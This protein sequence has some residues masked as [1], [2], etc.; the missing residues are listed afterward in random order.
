MAYTQ[1]TGDRRWKG[2][3]MGLSVVGVVV[4]VGLVGFLLGRGGGS[5][6]APANPPVAAAYSPPAV[7][8]GPAKIVGGVPSGYSHDQL[9]A[10][11][12]GVGFLQTVAALDAHHTTVAAVTSGLVSSNPSP[13]VGKVLDGGDGRNTGA[14]PE[15][16]DS[17]WV[18]TPLAF[19]VAAWS[20]SSA[21]VSYWSCLTGGYST[22]VNQPVLAVTLCSTEDVALSWERGDWRVA[23]YAYH[24]A[25]TTKQTVTSL[26]KDGGY[27]L[28][29]GTYMLTVPQG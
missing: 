14:L 26:V 11:S 13:A 20:G 8:A 23:D 6:S 10:I 24:P 19:K 5:A 4:V 29:G 21:A 2:L 15:G 16:I 9:G 27:R 28:L 12:A 25:S 1:V 17:I 22:A 3:V 7:A 18:S